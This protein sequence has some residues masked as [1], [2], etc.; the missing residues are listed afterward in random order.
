MI[1][2]FISVN[3]YN[4]AGDDMMTLDDILNE[5]GYTIYRLSKISGI[6]KTTLFDIF[7]GKSNILDCRLRVVSKLAKILGMSIEEIISLEPILYNPMYE[8]N[9]PDFLKKDILFLKNKKNKKDPLLD[10]YMDEANSS[11]NVCLVENIISKDQ[12][13]YLRNKYLK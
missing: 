8:D 3:R 12:A 13:D 11:I 9:I 6:S 7:S 1:F 10:C 2:D 4:N 5:K